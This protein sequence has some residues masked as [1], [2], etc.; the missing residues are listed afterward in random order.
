MPDRRMKADL[1]AQQLGIQW[2]QLP[3]LFMLRRIV[4]RQKPQMLA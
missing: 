1:I 3:Q 4:L 2:M